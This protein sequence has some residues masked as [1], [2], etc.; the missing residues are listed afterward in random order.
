VLKAEMGAVASVSGEILKI[1]NPS[2][3]AGGGALV[4]GTC[5][6]FFLSVI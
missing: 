3:V 6:Y 2:V 4:G 5:K 1:L